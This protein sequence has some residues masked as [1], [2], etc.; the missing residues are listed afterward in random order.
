MRSRYSAVNRRRWAFAGTSG[1]GA[2][3][4]DV[5]V[6]YGDPLADQ[7]PPDFARA[8]DTKVLVPDPLDLRGEPRITLGPWTVRTAE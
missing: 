6:G 7:L 1:S 5:A 8:I 2:V 4:A 3:A